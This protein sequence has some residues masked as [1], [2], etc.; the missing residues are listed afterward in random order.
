[1]KLLILLLFLIPIISV[2]KFIYLDIFQNFIAGQARPKK[3]RK[4]SSDTYQYRKA[5]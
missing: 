1:M 3:S 4:V 2:L 5:Q